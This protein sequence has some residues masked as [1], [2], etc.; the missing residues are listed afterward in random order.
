MKGIVLAG[1][2]GTRLHPLTLGVS[3]HL[4]PVYDKPMIY[5]PL[6][7][8]MLAGVRE[9]AIVTKAVDEPSYQ[10]LLGTGE[11]WGCRFQY[12][13]QEEPKGI[14]HAILACEEFINEEPVAVILGDN[15]FF[16]P[17]LTP[18]L[19]HAAQLQRGARVFC[20]QVADPKRFGIAE[21][22]DQ[23][24]VLGIEEKPEQ[25]RSNFAVTGLYF[26]DEKLISIARQIRCSARG[27][28]EVTC[29]NNAYLR[30]GEL[31][32]E[33]LGRGYAWLDTGTHE[34]LL[35]AGQFIE[36]VQKRQGYQVAD[37]EEISSRLIPMG[38]RPSKSGMTDTKHSGFIHHRSQGTVLVSGE[39]RL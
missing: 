25:P 30:R 7:I 31:S 22:D 33:V 12:V 3:K 37:L 5:Y 18:K 39:S 10:R 2:S 9:I 36:T 14:G 4:L 32:A 13:I 19:R 20:Y 26:F 16:G 8:L 6:S 38:A 17:G 11:Q 28:Y 15:I 24:D 29:I 35:E 27:E 21:I 23:G 34:A 1:G